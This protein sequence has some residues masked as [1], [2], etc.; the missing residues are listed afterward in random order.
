VAPVN[1]PLVCPSLVHPL[2]HAP[3]GKMDHREHSEEL[4]REFG[5]RLAPDSFIFSLEPGGTAPLWPDSVSR[6]FR[7][8]CSQAN[9]KDVRLHDRSPGLRLHGQQVVHEKRWPRDRLQDR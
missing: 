3:I 8:L 1:L 5:V 4:A 7:R 6:A 9:V 2:D